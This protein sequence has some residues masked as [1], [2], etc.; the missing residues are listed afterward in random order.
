MRVKRNKM[1]LTKNSKFISLKVLIWLRRLQ[2]R[3]FQNVSKIIKSAKFVND[4][5]I[6]RVNKAA[7]YYHYCSDTPIADVLTNDVN[8]I[9]SKSKS[10]KKVVKDAAR[11]GVNESFVYFKSENG[12]YFEFLVQNSSWL[13]NEF[14]WR[15]SEHRLVMGRN[16]NLISSHLAENWQIVDTYMDKP[17]EVMKAEDYLKRI[18]DAGYLDGP[19]DKNIDLT[20]YNIKTIFEELRNDNSAIQCQLFRDIFMI[21]MEANSVLCRK[22]DLQY[23]VNEIQNVI[24]PSHAACEIFVSEKNKWI[25]FDPY[26]G[27]LT[28]YKNNELLE[29]KEIQADFKENLTYS[30]GVAHGSRF[31]I[32]KDGHEGKITVSFRSNELN[33]W[34][35]SESGYIFPYRFLFAKRSDMK[36]TQ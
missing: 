5:L 9:M 8:W 26:L 16:H 27:G 36:V 7:V 23:N 12:E 21:A 34:Y 28:I 6:L 20:R 31:S 17:I 3:K 35:K 22:A 4:D 30:V 24:L 2:E 10:L 14:G 18:F 11:E 25:Y 32:S 1:N 15:S 29:L 19:T 33:T 13:S